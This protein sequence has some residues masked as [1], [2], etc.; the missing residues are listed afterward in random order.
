ML[1]RDRL[2]DLVQLIFQRFLRV[3]AP[4][5]HVVEYKVDTVESF[6]DGILRRDFGLFHFGRALRAAI[7]FVVRHHR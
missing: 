3:E 5:S 4:T 2:I 6:Y 1:F 7:L